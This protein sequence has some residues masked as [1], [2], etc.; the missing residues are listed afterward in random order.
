V[1][2]ARQNRA[3]AEIVAQAGQGGRVTVATNMAG[4]GTD[5]K[6]APGIAAIGGLYVIASEHHDARRVDRQ[7]FGRCGRQ[8]DPCD[9][10]AIV[11]LD[12]ELVRVVF[13]KFLDRIRPVSGQ[14][15]LWMGRCLF[16]WAQRTIHKR[17]STIRRRL[18][19]SDESLQDL[20]AFSGRGE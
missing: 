5:I 17:H 19:R 8:G 16:G 9:C 2:N 14:V 20:L 10:E 13:G 18:L 6:L 12:D 3:E 4:R 15:P 11:S 7:L 1:L